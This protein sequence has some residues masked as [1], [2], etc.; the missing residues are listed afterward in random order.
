VTTVPHRTVWRI[1]KDA[2]EARNGIVASESAVATDVG[3]R[4]LRRGGNAIDAAVATAFALAVVEPAACGLGGGGVLLLD[5]P[6]RRSPLAIDFAMTAPLAAMNAYE[7]LEG[8]GPSRFGWR[9]VRGDANVHGMA[10]AATPGFV[11]GL[12]LALRRFGTISFAEALGPAV[13]L[14]E[15]GVQ[16]AWTSTLRISARLRAMA[17][18]PDTLAIFAPEG[19]PLN[20]GGAYSRADVLVQKDLGRTLRVLARDGAAAFCHGE[21]A[22]QIDR[23]LRE[24]GGLI[25]AADLDS[26]EPS[27]FEAAQK[28]RFGAWEVFGIPGP[29]GCF[30]AQ[31]T[32]NILDALP[33]D[34]LLDGQAER[35]N[36]IAHASRIS[37]GERSHWS[38]TQWSG[39]IPYRQ[40]L[41]RE[42]ARSHARTI[43]DQRADPSVPTDERDQPASLVAES[44]THVITI[45]R[46]RNVVSLTVTLADNFGSAA[47]V[48]NTGI[49][50]NNA[51]QWFNPEPGTAIS[52]GPGRRGMH[53]MTPLL[54][55]RDGRSVLALGSAGGVRIIDAVTQILVN[56]TLLGMP[57]QEA[58]SEPRID[59]SG[60]ALLV[61]SRLAASLR[62]Q[63]KLLGHDVRVAEESVAGHQFSRP[64][65]AAVDYDRGRISAAVDPLRPSVAA[66]Y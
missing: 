45:D 42:H 30:T 37:F 35:L 40:I 18:F 9:K 24:M 66:G 55:R 65:V 47:T 4:I 25:T 23:S 33:G 39:A 19:R 56:C 27:V 64:A 58:I 51:M 60:D 8:I 49:V 63:L 46:E 38:R 14:A 17:Q 32:L 5:G 43:L 11:A 21:I 50:L 29:S 53:N 28:T 13:R 34:R 16:V 61:D 52:I 26:Y 7:L 10:A 62:R 3:L 1:Q 20:P 54:V 15:R 36:L 31:E 22:R 6:G 48:P 12:E 57:V 2:A 44:T 41:S 59:M